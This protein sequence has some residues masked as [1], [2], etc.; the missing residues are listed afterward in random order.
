ME[1]LSILGS[2]WSWQQPKPRGYEHVEELGENCHG[3]NCA[4]EELYRRNLDLTIFTQLLLGLIASQV[5]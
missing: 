2:Y 1:I 4:Y 5:R 3:P